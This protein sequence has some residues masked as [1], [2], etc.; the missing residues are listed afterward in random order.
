[1]AKKKF[2]RGGRRNQRVHVPLTD[3][4]LT[5]LRKQVDADGTSMST[6][7]RTAIRRQLR[8]DRAG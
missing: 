7:A 5:E 6:Y 1:M 3:S 4:E 2:K 8:R